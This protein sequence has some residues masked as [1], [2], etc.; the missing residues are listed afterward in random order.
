M[1]KLFSY[2]F[3]PPLP[4]S[5]LQKPNERNNTQVRETFSISKKSPTRCN[6]FS[7]LLSWRLF[8]PQNVSGVFTPSIKSSTTAVAASAFTFG[9]P[10]HD[11]Q[12]CYHHAP[13]VKPEA[14]TAVVEFLMISMSTHET[15]WTANKRQD[16]KLEKL[17]YLVELLKW[18][19]QAQ[20]RQEWKKVVEK[21][22]TL[23]EL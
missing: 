6:S 4:N 12:Y 2:K 21:A 19:E 11:Q 5:S 14:A 13:K 15:C 9:R 7:S 3:S 8:I 16:N 1:V 22:K 18:T 17:Y 20:N 10:D 23:Q